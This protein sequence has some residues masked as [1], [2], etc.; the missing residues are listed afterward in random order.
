MNARPHKICCCISC[1]FGSLLPLLQPAGSGLLEAWGQEVG[2]KLPRVLFRLRENEPASP[3]QNRRKKQ[4]ILTNGG[5]LQRGWPFLSK[6]VYHSEA[7]VLEQRGEGTSSQVIYASLT[8]GDDQQL[9]RIRL[10]KI[11]PYPL[12]VPASYRCMSS[13]CGAAS[14]QLGHR[15]ALGDTALSTPLSGG[16]MSQPFS[17]KRG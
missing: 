9:R 16:F 1:G 3:P 7:Y 8:E 2:E 11:P 10:Q 4:F 6:L 14:E 12:C 15:A 13:A 5:S 17:L